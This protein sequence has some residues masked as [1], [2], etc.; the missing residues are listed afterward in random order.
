MS[1]NFKELLGK[2]AVD[3]A[4]M[5]RLEALFDEK[6]VYGFF[7]DRGYAGNMQNFKEDVM[8][9]LKNLVKEQNI[10]DEELKKVAG[11]AGKNLNKAAAAAL[12]LLSLAGASMPSAG[13]A[14]TGN[15]QAKVNDLANKARAIAKENKNVLIPVGA[16]VAGVGAGSLVA[17]LATYFITGKVSGSNKLAQDQMSIVRQAFSEFAGI[18]QKAA[19]ESNGKSSDK[20]LEPIWVKASKDLQKS[21][22]KIYNQHK[23]LFDDQKK[24]TIPSQG[25]QT[26]SQIIENCGTYKWGTG[27]AAVDAEQDLNNYYIK[28][29]FDTMN[30]EEGV[31]NYIDMAFASNAATG[32]TIATDWSVRRGNT[33]VSEIFGYL[34]N[35]GFD[36]FLE[37]DCQAALN[38]FYGLFDNTSGTSHLRPIALPNGIFNGIMANKNNP[39]KA[40]ETIANAGKVFCEF[41]GKTFAKDNQN[42]RALRNYILFLNSVG[43]DNQA[44]ALIHLLNLNRLMHSGKDED[45]KEVTNVNGD[46]ITGANNKFATGDMTSAQEAD[47]QAMIGALNGHAIIDVG[48]VG[49]LN[50]LR[51]GYGGRKLGFKTDADFNALNDAVNALKDKLNKI[52]A[53][54]ANVPDFN[55]GWNLAAIAGGGAD[56]ALANDGVANEAAD[57]NSVRALKWL[58]RQQLRIDGIINEISNAEIEPIVQA[59]FNG[60]GELNGDQ[61]AVNNAIR[62]AFGNR[63]GATGVNTR[64][65]KAETKKAIADLAAKKLTG[66]NN[67]VAAADQNIGPEVT[68]VKNALGKLGTIGA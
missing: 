3:Q 13:A 33:R 38:E 7:K 22:K 36:E 37:N 31:R 55:A 28:P 26:I 9:L 56:G 43:D 10:S 48:T 18:I 15:A 51:V 17:G 64:W 12:S 61:N 47:L 67:A 59:M 60:Q 8:G 66:D 40:F 39:E 20:E 1:K 42:I 52:R 41:E 19:K 30:V 4:S 27:R 58:L 44:T 21:M 2:V 6:E 11:G 24:I 16:G 23:A 68:N 45:V 35:D 50:T 5:E 62:G 46:V 54:K 29:F 25:D 49:H 63:G 32:A 53:S 65:A 14:G 34:S 57:V